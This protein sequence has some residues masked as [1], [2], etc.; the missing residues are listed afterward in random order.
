MSRSSC[1]LLVFFSPLSLCNP[2]PHF[3]LALSD[4]PTS[5]VAPKLQCLQMVMLADGSISAFT[6]IVS[7]SGRP[8]T[9]THPR[10]PER[11]RQDHIAGKGPGAS[12][13]HARSI[14]NMLLKATFFSLLYLFFVH[15]VLKE[16]LYINVRLKTFVRLRL[17]HLPGVLLVGSHQIIR[18]LKK[19]CNDLFTFASLTS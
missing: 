8:N 10:R 1:V 13:C 19:I 4:K 16:L 14:Y 11:L 6:M 17:F 3:P 7:V 2:P 18:L 5:Q 15:R 9:S 12:F